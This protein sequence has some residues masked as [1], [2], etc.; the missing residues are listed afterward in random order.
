MISSRFFVEYYYSIFFIHYVVCTINYANI[1]THWQAA[2]LFF[3]QA[4]ECE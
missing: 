2:F 3:L 1:V 4:M